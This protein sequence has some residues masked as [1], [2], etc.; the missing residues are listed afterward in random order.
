MESAAHFGTSHS[1]WALQAL[2]WTP[3]SRCAWQVHL[4]PPQPLPLLQGRLPEGGHSRTHLWHLP[5]AETV[6]RDLLISCNLVLAVAV[7]NHLPGFMF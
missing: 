4:V 2:P 3:A 5:K 6:P 7:L 1:R